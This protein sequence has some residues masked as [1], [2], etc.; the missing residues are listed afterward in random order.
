MCT[1]CKVNSTDIFQWWAYQFCLSS[2]QHRFQTLGSRA[3]GGNSSPVWTSGRPLTFPP[4][5]ALSEWHRFSPCPPA[6]TIS[7]GS[8]LCC[9]SKLFYSIYQNFSLSILTLILQVSTFQ[10]FIFCGFIN[11]HWNQILG[12]SILTVE[13]IK[14]KSCCPSIT[15][16]KQ[17][18]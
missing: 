10:M 9:L 15:Y 16:A 8:P 13:F 4:D 11:I 2:S 6:R 7:L 14:K 5:I 17:T 18:L 12:I 1:E 3:K